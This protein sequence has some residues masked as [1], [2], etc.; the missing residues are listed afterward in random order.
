MSRRMQMGDRGISALRRIVDEELARAGRTKLREEA[1][2]SAGDPKMYAN[3]SLDTAVDRYLTK[4]GETMN[5]AGDLDSEQEEGKPKFS[6]GDFASDV[7]NLI[8]RM[9]VLV[10]LKGTVARRAV[11]YVFKTYGSDAAKSLQQT[12][13]GN[14]DI[15]IDSSRDAEGEREESRPAAVGAGGSGSP[16]G[17]GGG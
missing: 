1:E 3:D 12:L 9:D 15:E 11:N 16:A 2:L 10:D 5:A 6:P 13:S 4:A 14:F 17:G 8:E 7:A